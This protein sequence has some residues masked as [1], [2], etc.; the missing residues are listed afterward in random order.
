MANSKHYKAL[1]DRGVADTSFTE[2]ELF[3][4]AED[5]KEFTTERS[6]NELGILSWMHLKGWRRFAS[7]ASSVYQGIEVMGKTAMAI[8]MMENQNKNAD[9]AYLIANDALFDYSLVPPVV[10]GLRTSPIGIPFLTFMYKVIPK[11]ID[12]ALNNPFRFAPYVAMGYAL[13]QI[14]MH[15]FD[16][17]DDEYEKLL[18]LLPQ[19]TNAGT[20]FPLPIRDDAGRLQFLDFGYIMPWGF[21]NQLLESGEK[22]YNT[23]KGTAQLEEFKA[24]DILQTLGLFGGPGWSLAG[25]PLNIDPFSKRPIWK[26]GE[27]FITDT[28]SDFNIS[29]PGIFKKDGQL[30]DFMQY[31]TNQF[32]L[33]SFLHTEY[34][35]TNRMISAIN[36]A[37]EINDKNRLTTTQAAIKFV[38]L[39]T[40]AID[41]KQ[42]GYTR[43]MLLKEVNLIT[44]ERKKMLQNQSY[45]REDKLIRAEKYDEEI[46]K[47]KFKLALVNEITKINPDLLRTI[48]DKN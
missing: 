10:R 29:I 42:A 20:T 31:M 13:P 46:Q 22:G 21:I 38:G 9:E 41:E 5:F 44:A 11:L 14:F 18:A 30:I 47:I 8:E 40:F 33:P 27:P 37:G 36:E 23:I 24:N 32:M 2:A 12:V 48:R 35:A 45:S 28:G 26:E 25:L 1:L 6:I 15:M 7:A 17:D 19:Y 3:R 39:N 16:I 4:W 34:G 43:L